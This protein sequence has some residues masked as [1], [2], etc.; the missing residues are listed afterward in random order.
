MKFCVIMLTYSYN[1]CQDIDERR[2]GKNFF[3]ILQATV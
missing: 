1:K 2:L 3:E